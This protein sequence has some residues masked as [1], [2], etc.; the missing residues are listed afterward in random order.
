MGS[1]LT[2]SNWETKHRTI[3]KSISGSTVILLFS[4]G[5]D[6]SVLLHFFLKAREDYH[7]N[8]EVHGAVFPLHVL[9]SPER[10]KLSAF[11]VKRGID[12]HWHIPQNIDDNQ[13]KLL[14]EGGENPCAFCNQV[15]KTSLYNHFSQKDGSLGDNL[16]LVYGYSLWDLVSGSIELILRM[17]FGR[18]TSSR[19]HGKSA[20]DRLMDIAKRFFPI[21]KI[22]D[23]PTLFHPL[24]T[25]NDTEID[26][27]VNDNNILLSSEECQF[28]SFRP[29]RH[30]S[31]YYRF[32]DLE[33][34]FERVNT[35]VGTLFEFPDFGIFHQNDVEQFVSQLL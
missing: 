25:Y 29:K 1:V 8:L 10:S 17:K 11:W 34:D 22:P 24:I 5:K 16:V 31:T 21:V 6:S 2:Y 4:G 19:S 23:K 35:H 27:A 20:N 28:K 30:L 32:F 3:L 13:L 26:Q 18:E 9:K 15:K 12:I 14:A 7:F 33:F